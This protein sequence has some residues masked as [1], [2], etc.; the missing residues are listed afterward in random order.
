MKGQDT[1]NDSES[2]TDLEPAK[3]ANTNLLLANQLQLM[4][5]RLDDLSQAQHNMLAMIMK[6]QS[7]HQQ[8]QEEEERTRCVRLC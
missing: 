3:E 8:H 7:S 5:S 6:L 1:D 4:A 2:G